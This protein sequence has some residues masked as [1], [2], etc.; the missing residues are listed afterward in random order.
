MEFLWNNTPA[1]GCV[2]TGR[3]GWDGGRRADEWSGKGC[4]G[5]RARWDSLGG[6]GAVGEQ[7]CRQ[8]SQPS[9][10]VGLLVWPIELRETLGFIGMVRAAGLEPATPSV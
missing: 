8:V 1:T 6:R 3:P 5:W 2:L 10:L 9:L 4:P 7:T